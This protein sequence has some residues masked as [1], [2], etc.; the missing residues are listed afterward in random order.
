MAGEVRAARAGGPHLR[1]APPTNRPISGRRE[2]LRF[3]ATLLGK[4]GNRD[5]GISSGCHGGGL[6]GPGGAFRDVSVACLEGVSVE[7]GVR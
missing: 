1:A 2:N 5:F 7:N 6:L 4:S 3:P